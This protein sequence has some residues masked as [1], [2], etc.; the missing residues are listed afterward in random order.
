MEES[1]KE[2]IINNLQQAKQAGQLKTENIRDIVQKAV[3]EATAEV[4]EGRTEVVSLVQ[5]AIAAVIEIYKDKKGEIKEEVTA[6]IEGA[7]EGLSN[8]R[9]EAI[10]DTQSEIQ[11]L[12][13]KVVEQEEELQQE[14]DSALESLETTSKDKSEQVA[15]A[16]TE[17]IR[18][19]RNSEE[20]AL[21]QKRYAQL[22]AQLAIVQ[23]NLSNRYGENYGDV[24]QYLEDAKAW[25]K[26]ARE[27]P[28]EYT[29]KIKI[30]HQEFEDKLGKA[31]VAIAKRER[32]AKQLLQE[33]WKSVS[34]LFRDS[35]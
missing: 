5:E 17:A 3:S 30:S 31:G 23:A 10:A 26:K 19:V 27:N 15:A 22:K 29:G 13:V 33:L 6:S 12:E 2:K 4:K 14:I 25:Y 18:N 1:R 9:R 16:V 8:A 21:L 34:E 28:E 35:K 11:T 32:Q 7:I 24:N 20:V